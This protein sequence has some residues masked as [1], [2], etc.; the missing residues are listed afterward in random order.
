MK[1]FIYSPFEKTRKRFR[2]KLTVKREEENGEVIVKPQKRGQM[3]LFGRMYRKLEDEQRKNEKLIHFM[4]KNFR[5]SMA[6]HLLSISSIFF[7]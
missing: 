3:N 1:K 7:Q 4:L 5:S 2:N 6:S